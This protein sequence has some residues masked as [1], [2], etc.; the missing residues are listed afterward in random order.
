MAVQEALNSHLPLAS[1]STSNDLRINLSTNADPKRYNY[2]Y[3]YERMMERSQSK[4][5]DFLIEFLT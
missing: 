4:N 2:R 3:M 5:L 1:G